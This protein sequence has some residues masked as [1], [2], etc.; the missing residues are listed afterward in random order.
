MGSFKNL[1]PSDFREKIFTAVGQDWILVTAGKIGALNTMTASWGSFGVLW[2]RNVCSVFVRPSRH[3][4]KFME[5]EEVFTVSFFKQSQRAVLE[6]CGSHSG[7][8]C[9]KVMEAG[10]SVLE[11]PD[12][13]VYFNESRLSVICRKLYTQDLDPSR[14]LD[15]SILKSFYPSGDFH[16]MYV[17]EVISILEKTGE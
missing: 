9:D 15:S 4:Y 7:R 11:G 3:T 12:G 5:G 6:Y 14:I 2:N 1:S 13:G 8:D 16:R 17:G 10:L